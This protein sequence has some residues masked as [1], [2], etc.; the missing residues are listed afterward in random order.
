VLW[1]GIGLV[2]IRIWIRL[3]NLLPIT[4]RILPQLFTNVEDKKVSTFIYNS[5]SLY[6][7]NFFISV[8]RCHKFQYFG[9]Y[10]ELY[11]T[12]LKC[13]GKNYSFALLLVAMDTNPDTAPDRQA[14]DVG[15]VSQE[16]APLLPTGA[17]ERYCQTISNFRTCSALAPT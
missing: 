8:I 5:A 14:L 17:G 3:S 11:S 7:F 1:F 2:R 10:I 4:N 13:S 12:T 15:S 16:I 9:Q 6:C